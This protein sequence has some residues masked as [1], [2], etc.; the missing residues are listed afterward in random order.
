MTGMGE[1]ATVF[2]VKIDV[3]WIT[4][5]GYYGLLWIARV[6]YYGLLWITTT[7]DYYRAKQVAQVTGSRRT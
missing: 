4:M 1:L 5:V 3:L 6:G 2:Y 7:K